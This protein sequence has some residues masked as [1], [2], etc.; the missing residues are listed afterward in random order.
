MTSATHRDIASGNDSAHD[1]RSGRQCIAVIGIDGYTGWT[2]LHNAVNDAQGILR[3]FSQLGFESI[4]PPLFD[5]MATGDALR[6][7]AT[8][9]L[10]TLGLEDSL[11]LFFAGHGTTLTR[12][13]FGGASVKDG[14]LIP[15]DGAQP[16]GGTGSWLRLD[17]WLADVTRSPAK[18]ILVLLD[19]CHSGIALG[20]IIRWRSRGAAGPRREPLDRLR[21]RRSRRI[22]TSALDDQLA[23]D[24]GPVPGHSLFTGCIIEALTGGLAASLGERLVTGSQIGHYVQRRVAEYPGSTQTPD[25][26]SLELDDRGE[27]VMCIAPE[28]PAEPSQPSHVDV[29]SSIAAPAPT[30]DLPR[31][32]LA[33]LRWVVAGSS[34]VAV[35]ALAIWVL[36]RNEP[37]E[38]APESPRSSPP[39]APLVQ[40]AEPAD[41]AADAPAPTPIIDASTVDIPSP[42]RSRERVHPD[43]GSLTRNTAR[44][45]ARLPTQPPP[46]VDSA[47]ADAHEAPAT[48]AHGC[49]KADFAAVYDAPTPDREAVRIA[50]RNLKDCHKGGLIT[51]AEFDRYQSALVAK[52]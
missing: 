14:Y 34:V 26:G 42:S 2:R 49:S 15:V 6:R 35:A 5:E 40:P 13:Y 19:A 32:R 36:G 30:P 37:R 44:A 8:D 20:P 28:L 11:V 1:V 52:L 27:L 18:H 29:S 39:P 43:Q 23:M 12:T 25:F 9:D 50:L 48:P 38:T 46:A 51:D 33:A 21:A 31:P 47:V 7:L 3:L 45:D 4:G 41:A 10:A 24:G 22:V 17:S 16:G